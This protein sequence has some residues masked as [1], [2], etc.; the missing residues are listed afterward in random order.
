MAGIT[1]DVLTAVYSRFT[2]TSTGAHVPLYTS[3]G[4]RMY[5]SVAPQNAPLPYTVYELTDDRQDWQFGRNY[6]RITIAFDQYSSVRSTTEI[7]ALMHQ[8]DTLYDGRP[9]TSTG[10][11]RVSFNREFSHLSQ[12]VDE[13]SNTPIWWGLHQYQLVI[14]TT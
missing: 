5:L 7:T 2:T 13:V 1:K 10:F 3:L 6:R 12:L 9:L 4:G 14:S 11:T 8:L